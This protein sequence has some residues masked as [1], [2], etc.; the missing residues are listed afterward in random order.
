MKKLF[1]SNDPTKFALVDDDVFETIQKMCL[2]FYINNK[3][4]FLTTAK[5]KL[6]GTMKK[7]QLLLHHFVWFLKTNELP[8]S[9]VDHI[10]I[11]QLNNMFSNLRLATMQEQQR[12]R[13]KFKSNTSGFIGS[14][15]SRSC[16]CL[17]IR[18]IFLSFFIILKRNRA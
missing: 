4:Y 3:G 6:P 15:Q 9:T 7:K 12:H 18:S 16:I 2:K 17:A 1:A 10:D 13:G 14:G 8:S 5:V 11:N